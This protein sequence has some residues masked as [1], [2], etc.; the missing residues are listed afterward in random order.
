[1][2]AMNE[3]L[4]LSLEV[5]NNTNNLIEATVEK[6]FTRDIISD[7]SRFYVTVERFEINLNAVPFYSGGFVKILTSVGG[8]GDPFNGAAI[9]LCYSLRHLCREMNDIVVR[10]G[11]YNN[12]QFQLDVTGKIVIQWDQNH[13]IYLVSDLNDIFGMNVAANPVVIGG[14]SYEEITPPVPFVIGLVYSHE[15]LYPRLDCGDELNHVIV[16]TTLPVN[17]DVIGQQ[18]INVITDVSVTIGYNS[19]FTLVNRAETGQAMSDPPRGKLTYEPTQRRFSRMD[20]RAPIQ[21]VK[22]EAWYSNHRGQ[23]A[24]VRL[25]RGMGFAIKLGFYRK[26]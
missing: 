1:M 10:G 7:P 15:S 5:Q 3:P 4:Y 17:S 6:Q 8:G 2:S 12:L 21:N 23:L 16:T 11:V 9:P 13:S 24:R 19:D 14:I 18:L 26:S 20:S 25:G 22:I